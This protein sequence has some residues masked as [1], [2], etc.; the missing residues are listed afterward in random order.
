MKGYENIKVFLLFIFK[1]IVV[2]ILNGKEDFFKNRKE[3]NLYE[4]KIEI[5]IGF[6][7]FKIK[8]NF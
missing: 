3:W 4:V 8:D 2:K 6:E 5:K 1:I 7:S